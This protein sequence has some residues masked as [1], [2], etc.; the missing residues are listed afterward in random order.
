MY[1]HPH[2]DEKVFWWLKYQ[3]VILFYLRRYTYISQTAYS[4]YMASSRGPQQAQNLVGYR[5][6]LPYV[7]VKS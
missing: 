6:N 1:C 3:S 7:L 2:D 5:W 4:V